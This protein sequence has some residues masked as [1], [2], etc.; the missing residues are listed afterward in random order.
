MPK[1]TVNKKKPTKKAESGKKE[2][3]SKKV[4]KKKSKRPASK[5]TGP[6]GINWSVWREKYVT[7]VDKITY[8]EVAE[9]VGVNPAVER[10][11][12]NS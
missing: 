7:T 10:Y 3:V 2:T 6:K 11:R 9:K 4:N 1:K 5:S 12:R 8:A